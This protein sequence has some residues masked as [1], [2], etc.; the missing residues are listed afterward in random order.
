MDVN[1]TNYEEYMLDYLEGSLSE[2]DKIKVDVLG[3]EPKYSTKSK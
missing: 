1:V 3:I 2:A